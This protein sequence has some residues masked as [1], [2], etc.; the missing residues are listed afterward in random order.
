VLDAKRMEWG[1][2]LFTMEN[3]FPLMKDGTRE[4]NSLPFLRATSATL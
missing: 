1:C 2:N 3:L 4:W